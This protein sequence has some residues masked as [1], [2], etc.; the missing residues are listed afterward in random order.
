[1]GLFQ[2]PCSAVSEGPPASHVGRGPVPTVQRPDVQ[3][4]NIT[5]QSGTP[6]RMIFWM[7]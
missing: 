4:R 2:I 1:M 3:Q 6:S 5:M 7:L